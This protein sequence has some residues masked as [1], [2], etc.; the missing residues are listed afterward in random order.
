MLENELRSTI[1]FEDIWG[2]PGIWFTPATVI[3]PKAQSK[4][5][6]YPSPFATEDP[7]PRSLSSAQMC[8]DAGDSGRN[9]DSIDTTSETAAEK[10]RGGI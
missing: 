3:S 4:A 10:E 6:D 5:S 2:D 9:G 1:K 7:R 8:D